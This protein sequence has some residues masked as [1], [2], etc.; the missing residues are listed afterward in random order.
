MLTEWMVT[1]RR[2][3]LAVVERMLT[4]RMIAERRVVLAVVWM[5]AKWTVTG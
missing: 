4:K 2:I 1:G 3:V 5:L